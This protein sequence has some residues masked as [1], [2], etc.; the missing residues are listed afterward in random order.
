MALVLVPHP[1]NSVLPMKNTDIRVI[2]FFIKGSCSGYGEDPVLTSVVLK[3]ATYFFQYGVPPTKR[4]F[5]TGEFSYYK[6]L[7]WRVRFAHNCLM[8]G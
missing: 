7:D 8:C 5:T 2:E 6:L 1:A 3:S 4:R